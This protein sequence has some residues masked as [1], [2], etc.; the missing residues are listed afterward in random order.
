ME[1]QFCCTS[2]LVFH[3][4]MRK[5]PH[6]FLHL[7]SEYVRMYPCRAMIAMNIIIVPLSFLMEYL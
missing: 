3:H 5:V 2:V 6:A 4:S 1:T 7:S